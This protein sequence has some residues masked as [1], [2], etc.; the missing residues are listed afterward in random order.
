MSAVAPIETSQLYKSFF[1]KLG[2]KLGYK[3]MDDWYNIKKG[4]IVKN[5]GGPL[6]SKYDK[7]PSLALLVAYPD[8]EWIVEKFIQVPKGYWECQQ[9][10]KK[11]FD[12][13]GKQL[14]YKRMEDWYQ[15]KSADIVRHGG[16]GVLNHH[17]YKSPSAALLA[18]YPDHHWQLDRFKSKPKCTLNCKRYRREGFLS[19][20][21]LRDTPLGF[22][23]KRE[24]H[25][26]FFEW[27]SERIG[28]KGMEDWYNVSIEEIHENGGGTLLQNYYHNSPSSAVQTV[29]PEH[30]WEL[31][32]FKVVPQGYWST[33]T[34]N[35][36]ETRKVLDWLG[37]Q[38][39]IKS[40]ED[41][42]RVSLRRAKTLMRVHS[43]KEL[44]TMLQQSYPTHQWDVDLLF[45]GAKAKASQRELMV[46]V[47]QLFP[48]HG[49]NFGLRI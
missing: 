10:Q 29:F 7:S 38:L 12:R 43:A 26:E 44:E 28:Y 2:K 4:D 20:K 39:S 49:T 35:K 19:T 47:S 37:T 34:D 14:G 27:L 30:N 11:F 16:T 21:N 17:Y 5:Q 9:N 24:H 48:N 40:M 13:L 45:T 23:S 18:I 32:K 22:W 3:N 46:A 41:W 1:D 8:H 42:Y 31:W 33:L 6:L 36:E 25:R 15:V